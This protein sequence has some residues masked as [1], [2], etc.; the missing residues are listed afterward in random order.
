MYAAGVWRVRIISVWSPKLCSLG[1]ILLSLVEGSCN[2]IILCNGSGGCHYGC[3]C[4]EQSGQII[5]NAGH[6]A[7]TLCYCDHQAHTEQRIQ[8]C[9]LELPLLGG[10]RN[11]GI[12]SP[13][14]YPCHNVQPAVT[15][16]HHDHFVLHTCMIISVSPMHRKLVALR[17]RG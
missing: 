11:Y 16:S 6:A 12:K 10:E 1:S 4:Q 3:H 2:D 9:I 8:V 17:N 15:W 14:L 5:A 13:V 7:A